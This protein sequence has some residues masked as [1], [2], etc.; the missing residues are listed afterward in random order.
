MPT[1][2]ARRSP[3]SPDAP[4][5]RA[6]TGASATTYGYWPGLELD[7]Y[8]WNFRPD[9]A[10]GVIPTND[11]AANVFVSATPARVGRGG[12]A[13]FHQLLAES[14]QPELADRVAAAEAAPR[15][16]RS[17]VAPGTS[18]ARGVPAGRWSATPATSRTR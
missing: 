17:W 14:S 16:G 8:E 12:E 3:A 10:S 1:A 6:G 18:A 15:C 7:G 2:S 4:D 9:A 13:T 5:E 11:G